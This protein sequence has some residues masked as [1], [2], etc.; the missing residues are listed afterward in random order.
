M[1][2]PNHQRPLGL[3]ATAAA[4]RSDRDSEQSGDSEMQ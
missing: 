2:H 3:S 4:R 1:P